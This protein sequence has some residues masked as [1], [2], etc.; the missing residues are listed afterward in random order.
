MKLWRLQR[1]VFSTGHE[2]FI[3]PI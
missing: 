2:L 1:T 3:T